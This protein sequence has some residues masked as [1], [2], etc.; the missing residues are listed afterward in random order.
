[1]RSSLRVAPGLV[2]DDTTFAASGAWSDG[3][4]VRFWRGL[5]QVIGGWERAVPESLSG[6]CRGARTWTTGTFKDYVALGTH[7][8]L[9][10]MYG[11][12]FYDITP[13]GFTAGQADGAGGDGFGVMPYGD[14]GYGGIAST[15]YFP[16]TWTFAGWGEQLIANPRGRTLYLWDADVTNDAAALTNAPDVS[17]CVLVA[18]NRQ[19]HAFG[20][21]Q[22][23]TNFNP[24]CIR[25]SDIRDN[26]E[27]TPDPSNNSFEVVLEGG[28]RIVLALAMGDY[29]IV[30]TTKGAHLGQDTGAP[31]Q[32]YRYDPIPGAVGLI[33]AKAAVVVGSSAYYLGIDRQFYRYDLGGGMTAIP[34]PIRGDIIENIAS[35]QQDKIQASHVS[36]FNEVWF[37]Y[38]DRRDGQ[39][40]SRYVAINLNDGTWFRGEM[41]RSCRVFAQPYP[42][43]VSPD[44]AVYYHEKGA[45]DDG[46]ALS[47]YLESADQFLSE[48]QVLR[49]RG[50][51]PDL[52]DQ[53]GA[54][55]LTVITRFQPQGDETE[56][57]PFVMAPS[58]SKV[59]FMATGRLI[60]VRLE[61]NS[62]P[63]SWRLGRPIIDAVPA[64]TRG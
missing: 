22:V 14:G 55:N 1:V 39:E 44:G 19:V 36:E 52:K 24:M 23:D 35:A 47:A 61:S 15:D 58:A 42:I 32:P 18:P 30:W 53:V 7:T 31:N 21:T 63:S 17:T 57:G 59:D 56:R 40:N 38:P 33:G 10:V 54:V 51:M 9:Y 3:S 12:A 45:S 48:D 37:D 62:A 64:G 6:V 16:L 50:M 8:S 4:N 49:L 26:T 25:G 27:W 20:C 41:A 29:E 11:G 60:R 34:C 46:N 2:G 13:S 5:P 28:G 43:A